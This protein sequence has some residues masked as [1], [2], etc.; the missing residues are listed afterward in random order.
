MRL[1]SWL[2]AFYKPVDMAKP[3]IA[4]I[5]VSDTPQTSSAL[6]LGG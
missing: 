3:S 6:P 1:V 5:E 2:T 4:E